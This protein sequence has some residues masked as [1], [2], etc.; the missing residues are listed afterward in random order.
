MFMIDL[1]IYWKLLLLEIR[2]YKCFYIYEEF[3][4]LKW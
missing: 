2:D 1:C 3:C 4:L